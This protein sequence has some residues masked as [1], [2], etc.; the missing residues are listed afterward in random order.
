MQAGARR[1]AAHVSWDRTAE[2]LVDAYTAAAEEMTAR[3]AWSAAA[4]KPV[5]APLR[6]VPGAQVAR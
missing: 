4:R 3:T 2:S 1:H 6:A 5:L